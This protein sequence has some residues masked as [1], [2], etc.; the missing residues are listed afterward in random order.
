MNT[1]AAGLAVAIPALGI[2]IFLMSITQKIVDDI[3]LF[4]LKVQ[5]LLVARGKG[6]QGAAPAGHSG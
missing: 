6:E 2:F 5:Q 4:G 1:T 3:D